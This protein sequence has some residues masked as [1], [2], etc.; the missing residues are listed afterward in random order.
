MVA[1]AVGFALWS[2]PTASPT[3]PQKVAKSSAA[4]A[5]PITSGTPPATKT[6]RPEIRSISADEMEF[7]GIA[8]DEVARIRAA[9]EAIR[10]D[11][12]ETFARH[13]RIV[14]T[15]GS[16]IEVEVQLPPAEADRLE[17]QMFALFEAAASAE[18]FRRFKE[19]RYFQGERWV[20]DHFARYKIHY[21]VWPNGKDFATSETFNCKVEGAFDV[22]DHPEIGTSK[23][24]TDG[25]WIREHFL[26]TYPA[27]G[28][29]ILDAATK[30]KT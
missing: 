21:T 1:I 13:A 27:F 29:M 6:P 16:R 19:Q 9:K 28:R 30:P 20:L 17:R 12:Y 23:Y 8:S 18:T 5:P 22:P 14:L 15:D 11:T 24:G 7:P 10:K 25:V 3:A 26:E 2:R 4:V